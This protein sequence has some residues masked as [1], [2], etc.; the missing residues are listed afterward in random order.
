MARLVLL[1][2]DVVIRAFELGI[3]DKLVAKYEVVLARIVCEHDVKFYDDQVTMMRK[4]IDLKPYL[5]AGRVSVVDAPLE[6]TAEVEKTCRERLGGLHG[7]GELESIAIVK[8]EARDVLF[9]SADGFAIQLM[10]V[11]RLADKAISFERLLRSVGLSRSFASSG[12][13]QYSEGKFKY[14]LRRGSVRLAETE[15]L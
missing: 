3:W 5:A 10:A 13:L 8:N 12:D 1:D 6:W 9:C 11:L 14:W 15:N 2:A 4:G 7:Q